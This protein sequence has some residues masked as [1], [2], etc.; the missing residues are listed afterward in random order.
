MRKQALDRVE[1]DPVARDPLAESEFAAAMLRALRSQPRTIA[2]KFFYDQAGASLFERICEL[3]EYY[4]TRDEIAILREHAQAIAGLIGPHAD[5]V[6]FGAGSP[7]KAR[8]V[9]D[10]LTSPARYVPVDLSTT[11]LDDTAQQLE[12]AYPGLSVEPLVADFA[13][14]LTLPP[15]RVAKGRRVGLF[16]GSTIGNLAPGQAHDFLAAAATALSGGGLLIGVDLV[17]DPDLL[18]R[19]YNDPQGVTAAFNLNLLVRA[20][21]ELGADFDPTAFHH[22]AFYQPQAQRVEMHLVS[23]RRQIVHVGGHAFEF[24]EGDSLHT[25][26]SYK[27][28]TEGFW[29]MA[30]RAGFAPGPVWTDAQR[31]FSVRWLAA[32]QAGGRVAD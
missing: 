14:P 11:H 26:N 8:I 12:R 29:Q 15:R 4:L 30:Q 32:P 13:R 24:A 25:E 6:E 3:D 28:T 2:P 23:A 5:V 16:L 9:L 20:N 10:A 18:H 19:A 7:L 21:R 27:Y 1:F 17:K 31:R 22:Y